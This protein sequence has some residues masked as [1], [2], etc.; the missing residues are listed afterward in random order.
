MI[1]HRLTHRGEKPYTCGFCKRKYARPSDLKVHLRT[2]TGERPYAT[3]VC[4]VVHDGACANYARFAKSR[5]KCDVCN[6]SFIT[7]SHLRMHERNHDETVLPFPCLL[8]HKRFSSAGGLTRHSHS[9]L[10]NAENPNTMRDAEDHATSALVQM[11]F[12]VQTIEQ[13]PINAV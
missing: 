8:C 13:R 7:S 1:R 10:E 4:C 6:T 12:G 11:S 2:H 9:H 3:H 5:Y